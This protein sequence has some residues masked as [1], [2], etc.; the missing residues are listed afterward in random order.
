MY[1]TRMQRYFREIT[2][3]NPM[4]FKIETSI[5]G[6]MHSFNSKRAIY[7]DGYKYH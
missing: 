1:S 3:G 4:L 2:F 7:G 5:C 6:N